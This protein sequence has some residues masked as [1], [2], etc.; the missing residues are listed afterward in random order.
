MAH[1]SRSANSPA[2]EPGFCEDGGVSGAE[3]SGSSGIGCGGGG[4][5]HQ[6]DR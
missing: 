4:I 3:W 2:F 6:A 1:K 5:L